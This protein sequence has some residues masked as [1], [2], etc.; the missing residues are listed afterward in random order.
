MATLTIRIDDRLD[1]ELRDVAAR[2][3]MGK[4]AFVREAVRR[5]LAIAR[6]EQLRRRVAPFAEAHGWL[7]DEDVFKEVS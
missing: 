3:G 6:L 4:S 7:T 5:Q 2:T 1:A